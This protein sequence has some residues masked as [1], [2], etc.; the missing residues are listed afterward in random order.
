MS[1]ITKQLNAPIPRDV[2]SQR[3]GG[4]SVKLSYLEGWYVIDRLNQIVGVGNWGYNLKDVRL[5]W[6]GELE[7]KWGKKAWH[8][9]YVA[10]IALWAKIDGNMTAF[11]EVGYG[12]GQDRVSP[13]APH[14]LATKEAVTDAIKRAAKNLGM[15]MGLALYDKTQENVVDIDDARPE[16]KAAAKGKPKAKAVA[17]AP[18][19]MPLKTI[20]NAIDLH[21]QVIVSKEL[22][23]IAQ[24]RE[25]L[26]SKYNVTS[27]DKL[28]KTQ[29]AELLN[30]LKGVL[31]E[32]TEK[33]V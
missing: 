2:I 10:T 11:E 22:M 12:N 21:T 20:M 4:G 29:A 8:A 7:N 24:L 23:T 19:A 9:S 31:N 1:D 32:R 6:S 5:V 16:P 13:G 14:E 30:H 15:S 25:Q 17:K 3:D 27:K 28:T 18:A 26:Q 33:A